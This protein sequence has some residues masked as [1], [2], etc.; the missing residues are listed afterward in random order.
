LSPSGLSSIEDGVSLDHNK[1]NYGYSLKQS[2][3]NVKHSAYLVPTPTWSHVDNFVKLEIDQSA[4]QKIDVTESLKVIKNLAFLTVDEEVDNEIERYFA[5]M[6][7]KTK[8]IMINP[9]IKQ[10]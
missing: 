9:R 10:G 2:L 7:I 3:G 5:S 4:D 8:T 1:N 6:P